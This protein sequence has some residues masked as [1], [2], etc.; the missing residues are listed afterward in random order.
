MQLSSALKFLRNKNIEHK[1]QAF[2]Q[3][4]RIR[5]VCGKSERS[6]FFSCMKTFLQIELIRWIEIIMRGERLDWVGK[7]NFHGLCNFSGTNLV[8]N[9]LRKF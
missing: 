1:I 3:I 5:F 2:P 9:M 7:Q 4:P 6:L 8:E